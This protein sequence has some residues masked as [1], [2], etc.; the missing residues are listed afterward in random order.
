[1]N[2]I[3]INWVAEKIVLRLRSL[4]HR[5][6]DRILGPLFRM[7][8]TVCVYQATAGSV[9]PSFDRVKIAA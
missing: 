1:M 8:P 2:S 7:V 4:R 9:K 3:M 5:T 6:A